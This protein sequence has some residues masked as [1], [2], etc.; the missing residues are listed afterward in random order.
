MPIT[1]RWKRN[2]KPGREP[3]QEELNG[4]I[5]RIYELGQID[6]HRFSGGGLLPILLTGIIF[7]LIAVGAIIWGVSL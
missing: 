2:K 6:H 3:T 7:L 4:Y 5:A 1:K